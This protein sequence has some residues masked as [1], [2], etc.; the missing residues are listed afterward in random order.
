[1]VVEEVTDVAMLGTRM[2]AD[3]DHNHPD[4][5]RDMFHWAEWLGSQLKLGGLRVDAI[6]HYSA[7]FLRDL[8]RHIDATVGRDWFI[9]G[10]YW[11]ADSH[12]LAEYVD[13]M[14]RR[15]SLFD[16]ELCCNFSRISLGEQPDLRSVFDGTLCAL[17][18]D[19]TVVS[20]DL[21]KMDNRCANGDTDV[22]CEP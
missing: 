22:C 2:F 16:V 8:I 7:R 20:S 13:F 3:I 10:E 4:V 17:K 11:R 14:D 19:N 6:K 9:V 21:R 12:V 18:P 1:M 15:I 5:R